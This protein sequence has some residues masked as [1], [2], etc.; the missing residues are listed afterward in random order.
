MMNR[1]R[2]KITRIIAPRLA[3]K[4]QREKPRARNELRGVNAYGQQLTAEQ[5][6]AGN[7]RDFVGG[8]WDEVGTLQ[9]EYLKTQGLSPGHRLVDIGCG[10]LRGGLHFVRYLDQGNY[11][12]LDINASLIEAGKREIALAEL[13]Y[14]Q[15]NLL[16][17]D[18]FEMARFK[19]SFDYAI[20]HIRFY[21]PIHEP[22]SSVFS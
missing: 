5:I 3:E 8:L 12:G 15:P 1:V 20:C 14:K 22:Y 21:P 17:D 11:Y 2:T 7:H 10:A 4:I 6:A 13:T 16:V 9:V 18:R 19:V